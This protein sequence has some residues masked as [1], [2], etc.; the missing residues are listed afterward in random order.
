VAITE[1]A[2]AGRRSWLAGEY[3]I[4]FFGVVGVYALLD[5][6]GS[7][8]PFLILLGG[9]AWF[10]LR[11][12]PTFDRGNLWRVSALRPALPSIL[13]M[14]AM[15]AVVMVVA[16]AMWDPDRLFRLPREASLIWVFV[17]V[18]YPMLSVY[19]QELLFRAFL[20]HR[21]GPVF[22]N[23]AA[24]AAASAAAF[25]YAHI[26]Y[27]TAL[28][29]VLTVV[30]GWMFARRYQRTRSLLVTSVEH[31]LYGVLAFTIGLGDLF[32]HGAADR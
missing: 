5:S 13:L 24:S 3:L 18:F 15:V 19:P 28:A 16:V 26:I 8:I 6:P 22:G 25:G 30:A 1:E 2:T 9:A 27:G 11:R 12:Q 4:L 10:Y 20:M 32:Y 14:A 17:A 31:A 21:Y 7:P 29:V 23:G